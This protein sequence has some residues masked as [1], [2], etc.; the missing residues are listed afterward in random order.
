MFV[1]SAA[2]LA[3]AG[4]SLAKPISFNRPQAR[5]FGGFGGFGNVVDA[6]AFGDESI[7]SSSVISSSSIHS[8]DGWDGFSSLDNFD[9]FYGADNFC[10]SNNVQVFSQSNV[11]VC[12]TEDITLVQQ[13][14]AVLTEFA[15]RIIT[16]QICQVE[17]QTIV[18]SQYTA[19]L[20][21]FMD[22]VTH[23]SDRHVSF[24]SSIASQITNLCDSDGELST[25]DLGFLGNDIGSNSVIVQ[26]SNWNDLTSP[27]SVSSAFQACQ[28]AIPSGYQKLYG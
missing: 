26:G 12:Q 2:L 14:L 8:F 3:L 13:R 10:G 28:E 5:Q 18:L 11:I 15:K 25:G 7:D 6:S 19:S 17:V 23:V 20:Q 1:L 16:E 27:E 24:D 9:S 4:S 22:D 21:S